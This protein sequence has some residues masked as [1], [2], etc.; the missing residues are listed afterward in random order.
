MTIVAWKS[1]FLQIFAGRIN[2]MWLE[3]EKESLITELRR[4]LEVSDEEH[5]VLLNKVN[6]EESIDRIRYH[7]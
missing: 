1:P 7:A 2:K 6:E 3:Q 5:R 4:E